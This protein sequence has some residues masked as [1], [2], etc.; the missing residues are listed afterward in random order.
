MTTK[1][2]KKKISK[3]LYYQEKRKMLETNN[4][5]IRILLN[6]LEENIL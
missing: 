2:D 3:S 6:K 5:F 4:P 1:Q